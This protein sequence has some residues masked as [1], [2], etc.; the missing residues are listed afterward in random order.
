MLALYN[1]EERLLKEMANE[2]AES[3]AIRTLG[4]IDQSDTAKSWH[5]LAECGL[6]GLR[7]V[8]DEGQPVA[9]GVDVMIVADA[10]G[11]YLVGAPFL[12]SAILPAELLRVAGV[13]GTTIDEIASGAVRYGLLLG[14]DLTGLARASQLDASIGWGLRNADYALALDDTGGGLVRFELSG[15][16]HDLGS[17]DLTRTL[18]RPS[19]QAAVDLVG[20][21]DSEAYDQWLTL[22]LVAV[23]ADAQGALRASIQLAVEYAKTREAFG[24]PIGSFQALQHILANDYVSASSVETTNCF[25]AWAIGNLPSV[26]ALLAARTAKAYLSQVGLQVVEDLMQV[27]GGIGQTWEHIAHVYTR[28]VLFDLR[29]FGSADT[30]LSDIARL[31]TLAT[32][33]RLHEP[34]LCRETGIADWTPARI[35][36]PAFCSG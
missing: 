28:R 34:F 6:L 2:L 14:P 17:A 7:A 30:Q 5:R 32:K 4:D 31:R 3:M 27:L 9:T 18:R 33:A 13:D 8:G 25:A 19:A 16:C 1:S 35:R 24:A 10:L 29:V 26:E 21:L 22:A 12:E 20:R 36:G 15:S 23:C 11:S